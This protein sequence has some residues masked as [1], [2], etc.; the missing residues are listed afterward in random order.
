LDAL[1]FNFILC[2]KN[3]VTA[4]ITRSPARLLPT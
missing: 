4:C 2:S 3:E 1:T